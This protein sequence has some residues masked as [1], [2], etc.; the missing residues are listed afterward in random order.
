MGERA[1]QHAAT[2]RR[3]RGWRAAMGGIPTK[4]AATF[5][6]TNRSGLRLLVAIATS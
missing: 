5:G 4:R 3:W 1:P 2:G 6:S